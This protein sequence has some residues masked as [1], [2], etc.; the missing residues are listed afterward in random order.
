MIKPGKQSKINAAANRILKRTYDER[1]IRYCEANIYGC[2][3]FLGLSWHHRH[4]RRWYY[5]CPEKLAYFNQTILVCG[6]CHDI[7]EKDPAMTREWF[8]RLRGEE[9]L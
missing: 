4:K 7:L 1:E 3:S 6:N 8:L 9:I 2:E 5:S